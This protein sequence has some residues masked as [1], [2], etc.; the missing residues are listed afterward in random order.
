MP[1][2]HLADLVE[3]ERAA[4]APRRRG[5]SCA[6]FASVKAPFTW[7]KS[8]LSRSVSG[9]AAQLTATNGPVAAL[10]R[11]WSARATSSLPVP[12]SPVTSTVASVSATRAMI[13]WTFCIAGLV[14]DELGARL[15]RARPRRGGA[16]PPRG[17]ARF[18][19]ARSTATTSCVD[20]ERLGDEVVGAGAH[21]G[22][23]GLERAER[24]DDDDRHVV[25][26]LRRCARV[27]STP[28]MP[29]MLMSV[30]TTSKSSRSSSSQAPSALCCCVTT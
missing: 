8:S 13:S 5:P 30:T 10:L 3:E 19:S 14:A 6:V 9:I 24:G 18:W 28:F 26:V 1:E 29:R 25:A 23:R 21:R 27:S 12:L 22:D 16:S 4:A 15:R 7:P 11:S 2:R 20:L 17:G